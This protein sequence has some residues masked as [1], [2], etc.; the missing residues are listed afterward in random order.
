MH[1]VIKIVSVVIKQK[2]L[3]CI[4]FS[5]FLITGQ[6]KSSSQGIHYL[7]KNFA[8]Y[9]STFCIAIKYAIRSDFLAFVNNKK[10]LEYLEI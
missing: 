6:M 5:L 7:I 9:V 8:Y 1:N 10:F 2:L 4:M 3:T